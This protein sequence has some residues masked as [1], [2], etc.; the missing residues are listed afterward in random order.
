MNFVETRKFW[1]ALAGG[2]VTFISIAFNSPE[3]LS[4]VTL[5]LTALGVYQTPNQRS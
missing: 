5:L 1:T 4:G 2:A 3:W